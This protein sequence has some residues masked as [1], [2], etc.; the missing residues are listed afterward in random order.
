[1]NANANIEDILDLNDRIDHMST[2][3]LKTDPQPWCYTQDFWD[4]KDAANPMKAAYEV[5]QAFKAQNGL[6]ILDPEGSY[7][8]GKFMTIMDAFDIAECYDAVGNWLLKRAFQR[9]GFKY[10]AQCDEGELRILYAQ[11]GYS[12]FRQ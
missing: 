7:C 11:A 6:I 3:S 2:I 8:F 10:A 9:A 12:G 5:A 1:M 4:V